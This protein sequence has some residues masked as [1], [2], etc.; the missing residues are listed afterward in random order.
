MNKEE[1]LKALNELY[2]STAELYDSYKNKEDFWNAQ[3]WVNNPLISTSDKI[4]M[5]RE[6]GEV[7]FQHGREYE[8]ELI[9]KRL[10][11]EIKVQQE[12]RI[13]MKDPAER[14]QAFLFISGLNLAKMI[15]KWVE[16]EQK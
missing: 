10:D 4:R 7:E 6:Q 8:R 16:R 15:I 11:E 13:A 14:S 12:E 3:H 1:R 9:R 2:K 5:L